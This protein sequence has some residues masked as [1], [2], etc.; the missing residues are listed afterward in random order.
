MLR[1]EWWGVAGIQTGAIRGLGLQSRM[2]VSIFLALWCVGLPMQHYISDVC[3]YG[4]VGLWA[5][6]PPVY[7]GLDLLLLASVFCKSWEQVAENIAEQHQTTQGS[8]A[9][10]QPDNKE[11]Y[12]VLPFSESTT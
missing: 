5:L 12:G 4:V 8:C 9:R 6:M 11:G 3:G 7:G 1:A 10:K 2:G